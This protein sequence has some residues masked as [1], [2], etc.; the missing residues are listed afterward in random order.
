MK[1][2]KE[3]IAEK[4]QNIRHIDV[5]VIA[6][7]CIYAGIYKS[8]PNW[9]RYALIGIGVATAYYNGK[10]YITNTKKK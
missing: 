5:F 7:I 8:N 6:P 10:N 2:K 4:T 1:I 3:T 9:I